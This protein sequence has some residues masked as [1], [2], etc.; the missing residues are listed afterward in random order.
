MVDNIVSIVGRPNVGK[1]TL[2]NR[3][4]GEKKAVVSDFPGTTK[5]RNYAKCFWSGKSFLLVDTGGFELN[6]KEKLKTLVR[7]QTL[8]AIEESCVLIFLLDGRE[9]INPID[10]EI[11]DLL[12]KSNKKIIYVVNKI[13]NPKDEA[14]AL[15]FYELGINNFFYIS[16][17]HGLGI[18]ELL[19]EII[20]YLSADPH[21]EQDTQQPLVKIAVLGRPNVGKSSIINSIL[22][23]Q[24]FLVSETPGTTVDSIDISLKTEDEEF[25][26]VDTAGIRKK[27]RI[28]TT[29]EKGSTYYSIKSLKKCYVA[30]LV[31]DAAEGVT[32]QDLKIANLIHNEGKGFLFVANKWDIVKDK[33]L[34]PE[35]LQNAGISNLKDIAADERT[36]ITKKEYAD[37]I[38]N[39]LGNID[40]ANIIFTSAKTGYGIKSILSLISKTFKEATK[41]IPTFELNNRLSSWILKHHPPMFQGKE[42]K[43]KYMHQIN[44]APPRFQIFVNY[45]KGIPTHYCRYLEKNIRNDFEFAGIPIRISF[46]K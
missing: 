23:K 10:R 16:S 33:N 45:P 4:L 7:E 34:K 22:G 26:F 1:S 2:F 32:D 31:V 8:T 12:R 36:T 40:Y 39:R 17:I 5:D 37:F 38:R 14:M 9:G 43:I 18:G 13:D 24:R 27:S 44:T 20:S 28:K 21:K 41:R 15:P 6:P 3:L 46:K 30:V 25:L 11:S 35:H 29:L 19:D 42:V